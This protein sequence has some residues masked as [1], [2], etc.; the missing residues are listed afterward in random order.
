[1]IGGGG[2]GLDARALRRL[3][4]FKFFSPVGGGWKIQK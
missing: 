2:G 4:I 3:E 1:L